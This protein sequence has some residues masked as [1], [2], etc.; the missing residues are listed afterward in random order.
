MP[1]SLL[2]SVEEKFYD[3]PD[4]CLSALGLIPVDPD[5]RDSTVSLSTY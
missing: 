4:F 1:S 2:F 3:Y 5:N